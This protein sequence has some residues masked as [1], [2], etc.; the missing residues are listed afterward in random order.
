ML[1]VPNDHASGRKDV[2]CVPCVPCVAKAA[3]CFARGRS[4]SPRA[5]P[6]A[7]AMTARTITPFIMRHFSVEISDIYAK[8]RGRAPV[9]L[10]RQAAIYVAHVVLRMTYVE[11]GAAF[12]RDRTTAAHA[13][14][15]VE[16]RRDDAAFDARMAMIE[17][18]CAAALA[19]GKGEV[20]G[21]E[22]SAGK[23]KVACEVR[24]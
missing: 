11:A 1:N 8:D 22:P 5:R 21:Q 6:G 23:S 10:A 14:R 2:P 20:C 24:A 3:T 7:R 17:R 4:D 13:C 16:D 15:C 18:E 19:K 12:G 9:A